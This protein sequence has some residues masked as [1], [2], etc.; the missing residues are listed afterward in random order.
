MLQPGS[1]LAMNTS[2]RSPGFTW[3]RI[4]FTRLFVLLGYVFSRL[5]YR[6]E[7]SWVNSPPPDVWQEIQVFAFLNHTS[8][9]EPLFIGAMPFHFLW[10]SA[11][12]TI[13]PG[14]DITLNR[15]LVGLFYRAFSP[16]TIPITRQRDHSWHHFLSQID[17]HLM[18]VLAPEGRMMRANGLDKDGKP[19]SMRGGIADILRQ[20]GHGKLV[21][22]YSGGMHHVN[23]PGQIRM[24]LF[25]TLRIRL[26]YLD[27]AGYLASLNAASQ[28]ELRLKVARDL[29][30]R[31]KQFKP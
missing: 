17:P 16:G 10:D 12:R 2:V 15:P 11:G 24:N 13:I 31:L 7:V 28:R 30:Q 29:E 5:F 25:K 26:E 4:W 19:M 27:I 6:F 20:K 22:A 18:V 3:L 9:L 8:L 21:I 23:C 14:A 1:P